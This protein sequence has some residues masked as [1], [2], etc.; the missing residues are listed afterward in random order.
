MLSNTAEIENQPVDF[1][2]FAVEKRTYKP[3]HF[4]IRD[5]HFVG[6]DGFVVPKDRG[7]IYGIRTS[8]RRN[9]A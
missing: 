1:P 4:R 7:N 3:D 6:R 9:S 8:C 2:N 5:G